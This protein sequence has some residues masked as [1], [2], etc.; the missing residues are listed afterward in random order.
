MVGA[1]VPA[2]PAIGETVI[3]AGLF[4]AW[5][6]AFGLLWVYRSTLGA[7]ARALADRIEDVAI[8]TGIRRIHPFGPLSDAIRWVD[9]E[10]DDGLAWAVRNT[11][12]GATILF[13]LVA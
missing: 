4:L 8:P 12:R 7:I 10:I 6:V 1:F 2:A 9:G 13:Q 3:A 11:Q 5:I